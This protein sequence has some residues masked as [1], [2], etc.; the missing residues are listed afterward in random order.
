MNRRCNLSL[1]CGLLVFCLWTGATCSAQVRRY[2]PATPT[3]SPYHNLYR[4][5]DGRSLPNYYSLVRPELQQRAINR[6]EQALSRQQGKALQQ[7]QNDV[8]RGLQPVAPTGKGSWF[9]IQGSK[10]TFLNSSGYF[11]PNR[12]SRSAILALME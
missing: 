9:M 4:F 7:L 3:I 11:G 12:C 8:Q 1:C 10:S 2:Q 5:N 6:R